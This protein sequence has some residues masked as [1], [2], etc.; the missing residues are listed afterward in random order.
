MTLVMNTDS[1]GSLGRARDRPIGCEHAVEKLAGA[2]DEG[3]ALKVLIAAR[4]FADEHDMGLRIAVGEAQI[5]GG[6]A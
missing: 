5:G 6:A 2:A 1:R 4:R 3:L